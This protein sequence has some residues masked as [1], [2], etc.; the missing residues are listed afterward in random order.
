[1]DTLLSSIISFG[2]LLF[3]IAI[4]IYVLYKLSLISYQLKLIIKHFDIKDQ[5]EHL[6]SDEE[7]EKELGE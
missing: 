6:M 7:I 4:I 5:R 3:I 1:M 2:F